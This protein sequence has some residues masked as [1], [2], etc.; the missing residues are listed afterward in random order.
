[1]HERWSSFMDK[2][3]PDGDKD[4]INAVF[5]YAAAETLFQVLSQCSNDLSREK[6]YATGYI[7]ERLSELGRTSGHHVQH[8]AGRLPPHQAAASRAVRWHRVAADW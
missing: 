4:D 2:Y 8:R 5:G 3:Y 1:M 6:H 7:L